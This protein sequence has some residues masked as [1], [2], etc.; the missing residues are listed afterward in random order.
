MGVALDAA[1]QLL[2]LRHQPAAAASAQAASRN[3]GARIIVVAS[4]AP[5]YGPGSVPRKNYFVFFLFR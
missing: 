4:G 2:Q 5:N 3:V 1:V